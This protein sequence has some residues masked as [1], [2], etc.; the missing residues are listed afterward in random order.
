M[1]ASSRFLL[2]MESRNIW[3]SSVLLQMT[4]FLALKDERFTVGVYHLLFFC[5]LVSGHLHCFHI[6]AIVDKVA[7]NVGV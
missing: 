2:L 5:S 7:M 4:G 1:S 6:L 3:N